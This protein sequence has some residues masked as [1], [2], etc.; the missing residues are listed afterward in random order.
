MFNFNNWIKFLIEPLFL[1]NG[2]DNDNNVIN[3]NIIPVVQDIS[4]TVKK[5]SSNNEI[6]LKGEFESSLGLT[7]KYT[8][9]KYLIFTITED[10]ADYKAYSQ[11]T[12]ELSQNIMTYTPPNNFVGSSIFTYVAQDE[13]RSATWWSNEPAVIYITV[14]E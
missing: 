7:S 1:L 4:A 14:E 11:G 8:D 9:F 13:E 3:A 5:N 10:N 6:E 12:Y 2:C